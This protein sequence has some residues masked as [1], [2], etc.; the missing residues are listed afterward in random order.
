VTN[1]WITAKRPAPVAVAN[2]ISQTEG[3]GSLH[4]YEGAT[5]SRRTVWMIS[6]RYDWSKVILMVK[7][8]WQGDCRF[9]TTIIAQSEIVPRGAT[10][11]SGHG[12]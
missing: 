2:T 1:E 7:N 12:R 10:S 6:G 9:P 3:D 11:L 4:D 5:N 8:A